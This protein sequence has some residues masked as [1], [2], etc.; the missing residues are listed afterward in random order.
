M[1]FLWD[2]IHVSAEG[3]LSLFFHFFKGIK[4][5][6]FYP[7]RV[8]FAIYN[9]SRPSNLVSVVSHTYMVCIKF[10]KVKKYIQILELI[11]I[12]YVIFVREVFFVPLRP[13]LKCCNRQRAKNLR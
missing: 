8:C 1:S 10:L 2:V 3:F 7:S 9:S 13:D 11:R 12:G 6:A 4:F 5:I